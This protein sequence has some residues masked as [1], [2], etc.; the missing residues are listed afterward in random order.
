MEGEERI[1]HIRLHVYD[2]DIPVN[3]VQ[4]EEPFYRNAAKLIT[5]TVNHYS[6]QYKG[7]K[8]T[9]EILYMSM[10]AIALN[11]EFLKES[12]DTDRYDN[13]LKTL[14]AEIENA[15]GEKS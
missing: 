12:K 14:T 3:V 13:I 10:I 15:L 4:E 9:K 8:S 7:T 5:D 1:I 11:F 2:M 6:E